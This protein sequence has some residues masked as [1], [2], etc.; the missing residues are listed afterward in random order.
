M[1]FSSSFLLA[2]LSLAAAVQSS[3]ILGPR[4]IGH[5]KTRDEMQDLSSSFDSV[6]RP[7]ERDEDGHVSAEGYHANEHHEYRRSENHLQSAETHGVSEHLDRKY[8]EEESVRAHNEHRWRYKAPPLVW[9]HRLYIGALEWA[10][11]CDGRHS[12]VPEG[13]NLSSDTRQLWTIKQAVNRWMTEEH[14][15]D[16]NDPETNFQRTGHFTQIV[17]KDTKR[18]GCAMTRCETP[19]RFNGIPYQY[20]VCR[21]SPSGNVSGRY[22]E[23]VDR[24][25]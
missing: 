18:V 15:Y 11:R 19:L 5:L 8:W 17:W 20:V 3:S 10:E 25:Y 2:A 7:E 4:V 13:E 24:P 12:T 9:D 21:Y 1:H 6:R 22:Q 14:A 16:Y 23:N